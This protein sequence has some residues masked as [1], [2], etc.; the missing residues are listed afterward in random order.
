MVAFN[1]DDSIIFTGACACD[2]GAVRLWDSKTG[3]LRLTIKEENQNDRVFISAAVLSSDGKKILTLSTNG[4]L[5][6]WNTDDGKKIATLSLETSTAYNAYSLRLSSDANIVFLLNVHTWT[7]DL[8]D[9]E[10]GHIKSVQLTDGQSLYPDWAIKIA[11]SRDGAFFVIGSKEGKVYFFN[12]KTGK[13]LLLLHD[14]LSPITSVAFNGDES[15]ISASSKNKI[16][17][18][19]LE[20][21]TENGDVLVD[22]AH[23]TRVSWRSLSDVS[24]PSKWM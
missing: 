11:L 7:A 22:K 13:H 2:D 14:E 21:K 20:K 8:W 24:C 3:E 6:F 4:F 17:L 19:S 12:C 15:V 5:R 10:K 16:Y 9:I 1:L 23:G 18:W